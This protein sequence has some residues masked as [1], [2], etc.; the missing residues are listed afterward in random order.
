MRLRES[1]LFLICWLMIIHVECWTA[2]TVAQA[3]DSVP[4]H[5]LPQLTGTA[6]VLLVTLPVREPGP[7][8]GAGTCR[9]LAVLG[10]DQPVPGS[11]GTSRKLSVTFL[12]NDDQCYYYCRARRP[13][14]N[15]RWNND[16]DLLT[17]SA[18]QRRCHFS[19]EHCSVSLSGQV[20]ATPSICTGVVTADTEEITNWTR[21][22]LETQSGP[23]QSS[24]TVVMD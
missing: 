12:L 4:H 21:I 11:T 8:C 17:L 7:E 24:S 3:R 1:V 19:Q 14:G 13:Q 2:A 15:I 6:A 5:D 16:I 18:V 23:S 9:A 22:N 20:G 10:P